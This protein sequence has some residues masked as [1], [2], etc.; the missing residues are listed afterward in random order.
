MTYEENPFEDPTGAEE[1]IQA[2]ETE[3]GGS[4]DNEIYPLLNEWSKE[5]APAVLVEIGSGQGICSEKVDLGVG[6][7]IGVEPSPTLTDRAKTLY[8]EPNKEFLIGNAYDLPLADN[9]ADAAFSVGVWFHLENLDQA[10][11]EV[12]RILKPGGELLIVTSNPNLHAVW[13]NWFEIESKEG[14][15]MVG[16]AHT[17]SGTI[18]RSVF[19]LHPEEDITSSLKDNGFKIISIKKFGFG[20]ERSRDDEGIWMAIKATK[21]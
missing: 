9:I 20:R 8:S 7:Y 10:H 5:L 18:S 11:A 13:E 1:W 2:I 17:P 16:I 14:K 4:R 6:R 12:Y 15:K 21:E 3:K 19:F